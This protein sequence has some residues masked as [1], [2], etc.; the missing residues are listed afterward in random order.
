MK[1]HA[2]T[3]IELMVS[4]ALALLLMYGI[5]RVFSI[6]SQTVGA[7]QG[8]S[9]HARDARAAQA[10]FAQDFG[11]AVTLE[12]PFMVIHSQVQAAFRN[13][14]DLAADRDYPTAAAAQRD[15][16]TRTTDVN[17]NNSEGEAT[18]P[19]EIVSPVVYNDRNHRLDIISFFGR[20]LFKRQ[21][22]GT[23]ASNAATPFV[24]DMSSAEAWVWYGHLRIAN[25]SGTATVDQDP[26]ASTLSLNGNNFF[27]TDWILGREAI[28][29]R[30]PDGSG[31][32]A[33][34]Q[35][36]NQVF[37]RGTAGVLKPL[38]YQT[39][40][41]N[42]QPPTYEIQQ[43]RY[44]LASTSI[45]GYRQT[46]L[47]YLAATPN[48]LWWNTLFG[49]G[50]TRFQTNPFIVKPITPGNL[51]QQSPIF[52]RGA[53]QFIVEYAGDYLKQNL[54]RTD[55]VPGGVGN[56][57]GVYGDVQDTY[58]RYD[59]DPTLLD[60]N[61]IP[62]PQ[63]AADRYVGGETDGV[64]DF[65]VVNGVKRI[66]WYGFPRNTSGGNT[67]PGWIAGRTS[68]QMPEVVPLRDVWRASLWTDPAL[69]TQLPALSPGAPFEKQMPTKLLEKPDY[70][71]VGA[72]AITAEYNC[73]FG[74]NDQK[75]KMIRIT[76][77]LDDPAGRTAEGQTFEYVFELP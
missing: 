13:R 54:D 71:A 44:D 70:A 48:G 40:D 35:G 65:V 26:G 19:G 45:S 23:L 47:D 51:S 46:M 20:G 27:A 66:R 56:A 5:S 43:S 11:S 42:P 7:N 50:G 58:K 73:A 63:G 14:A 33:D 53:T 12:A 22:G 17:G 4:I 16:A 21:T 37:I 2:F 25:N 15:N 62:L 67:I 34:Q 59:N 38:A 69:P 29:L 74:P 9:E 72:T 61:G 55:V 24:A 57:L 28:L 1:R 18:V 6:T 49:G 64:I 31:N 52:L 76:L 41:N 30:E 8:I 36:Q 68:S 77:V 75:P 3:L 32:I 39:A 10:V 60:V